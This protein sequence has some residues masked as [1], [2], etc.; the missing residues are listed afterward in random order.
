MKKKIRIVI[1]VK[2]SKFC[3][4]KD[5]IGNQIDLIL[6]YIKIHYPKNTYEVEIETFVDTG[7]S[8]N[9]VSDRPQFHKMLQRERKQSF[10]I[11]IVDRIDR[12]S[13]NMEDFSKLIKELR[14]LHTNLISIKGQ[15]NMNETYEK[16]NKQI[17]E[18]KTKIIKGL[19]IL[20]WKRK[21]E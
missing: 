6:E 20:L 3:N 7:F 15:F 17:S 1:Y 13:E 5:S 21:Y 16:F 8:E 10:D 4:E 18:V 12:I 19:G 9:T 2:Q 14:K 11:L